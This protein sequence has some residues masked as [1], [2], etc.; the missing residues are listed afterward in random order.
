MYLETLPEETIPSRQPG[1]IKSW[2]CVCDER[3]TQA[4]EDCDEL[5]IS[6]EAFEKRPS[7]HMTLFSSDSLLNHK[8]QVPCR[9][10]HYDKWCLLNEVCKPLS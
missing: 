1:Q 7:A 4:D 8:A 10:W 3:I 9:T 5:G 6:E 2:K